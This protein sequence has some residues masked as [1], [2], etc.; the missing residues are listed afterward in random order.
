MLSSNALPLYA[1]PIPA[2]L[3]L[4]A[5]VERVVGG[6]GH[7]PDHLHAQPFARPPAGEVVGAAGDPEGA[8]AVAAEQGEH[9]PHGPLRVAAAAGGRV[10]VVADVAV[11]ELDPVGVADAERTPPRD[12]Q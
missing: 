10:D 3:P 7:D 6:D 1:Q 8:Q 11:V 12:P 4:P 2:L 9:Q 5:G